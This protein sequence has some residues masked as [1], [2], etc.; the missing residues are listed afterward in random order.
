MSALRR[1][2]AVKLLATAVALVP[3]GLV[4]SAGTW[5]AFDRTSAMPG[6]AVTTGTLK[7]SDND[8]GTAPLALTAARPGDT[9]TACVVVTHDGTVPAGVTLHGTVGGTGLAEALTLTVTRGTFSGT[10]AARSCTGFTADASG[11]GLYSGPLSGF[12]Q[13]QAGAIADP[14]ASWA[15]GEAHAYRLTVTMGSASGMAG[16]TATAAFAFSGT[17]T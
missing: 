8:G 15:P 10:P 11:A 1:R 5:S 2:L 6:N 14:T 9:T 4:W 13:T 12:P 16:K 7:L 17:S 3:C